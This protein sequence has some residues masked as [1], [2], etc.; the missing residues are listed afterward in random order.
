[1]TVKIEKVKA[2]STRTS[3]LTD[4]NAMSLKEFVDALKS[5]KP[6]WSFVMDHYGGNHSNA[7]NTIRQW[8]GFHFVLQKLP[9]GRH[10]VGRID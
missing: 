5:L 6:G 9:D 10:R 2:I 3:Y 1:M 4:S 7:L 8:T